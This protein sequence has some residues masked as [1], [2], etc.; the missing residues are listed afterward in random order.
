MLSAKKIIKAKAE[1]NPGLIGQ[2]IQP[3][4]TERTRLIDLIGPQSWHMFS[5]FA[6]T[7]FLSKHPKTWSADS[8]FNEMFEVIRRMKVVNDVAERAV[9]LVSDYA[10]IITRD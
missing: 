3:M 9:K 8:G 2:P 1:Y 5:K 10:E 4:I 6:D 7:E